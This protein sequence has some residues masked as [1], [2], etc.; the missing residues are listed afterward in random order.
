MVV[1]GVKSVVILLATVSAV[2]LLALVVAGCN[3]NCPNNNCP[4]DPF[5][6]SRDVHHPYVPPRSPR[7]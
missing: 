3:D 1:R 6:H 4:S 7:I 2:V 5:D